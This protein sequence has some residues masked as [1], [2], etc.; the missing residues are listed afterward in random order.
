M[1]IQT[2]VLLGIAVTLSGCLNPPPAP[3]ELDPK[4]S[5]QLGAGE[6]KPEQR[7]SAVEEALLPPLRMEMPSV[8]GQPIEPRFDLSVNN[9]P[10]QQVFLSLVN[11]TR[12]SML[13]H[14]NVSGTI[15]LSLKDVTLR[16]ALESI[17]DLYG[18]EFRADG[19]RISVQPAGL[20]TRVF[21]VNYL[22]GTRRGMSEVRVQ[23]G[24]VADVSPGTGIPG[25]P[26]APQPAAGG[27]Q[28]GQLPIARSIDSSR[29]STTQTNDFWTE[30]RTS[31]QSIIGAGPGRSVV[32]TAHSGI[33]VVRA[34]PEELRS[35]ELYLRETRL[36]VERQVMLEA[37]IVEVTLSESFQSGINWAFFGSRGS[38]AGA[39]GQ[40]SIGRSATALSA[41]GTPL[42]GDG[43]TIDTAGR[44]IAASTTALSANNPASS[45]FGLALQTA[46]FASLIQFLETQGSVQVLSSPRV[47]TINNQKAV[48]KVGTDE[49]F[50]TNVATVSTNTA[51]SSQSTPTVTTAPF[52]SGILLDVTPR[53]DQDSRIMLHIHPSVSSVT[54][55]RREVA[56]GS[57]IP[58]I[59]LPLP[60]STVSETDTIVRVTDGNIVAIGGLMSVEYID[61]RGGIT[62]LNIDLLRTTD[63]RVVKK[64]LVILLKPTV[65]SDDRDWQPDLREA[66]DRMRGLF[67]REERR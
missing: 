53:I 66:Q 16:E 26:G 50:V 15:S 12:Y 25:Q 9:A 44:A 17:R 64:E 52:F 29:I 36:S 5:A 58:S 2:V 55:S 13:V 1:K 57:N 49:F 46:N 24:S 18:Y 30:L 23:S 63:R 33:I 8:A 61:N 62:G 39:I 41:R 65:I 56:L 11:G 42:S 20:Q 4:I 37:K 14:P 48:L 47:A 35:V 31:L 43:V 7:P 38:G 28:P 60:K 22:T 54:E 59:V 10:A 6:R 40:V 34:M 3:S 21:R 32:V 19:S 45:V 51:I 67:P 27:L